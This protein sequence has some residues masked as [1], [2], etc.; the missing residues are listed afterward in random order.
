MK[1][2]GKLIRLKGSPH[3]FLVRGAY[4]SRIANPTVYHA[5]EATLAEIHNVNKGEFDKYKTARD[6]ILK[7]IDVPSVVVPR[8]K[9][10]SIRTEL[11]K[12]IEARDKEIA[13]L[14]KKLTD[15]RTELNK[16]I[17]AR[18]KEIAELIEGKKDA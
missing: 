8:E 12:V 9:S 15:L 17:E 5:M 11:N 1:I 13:E 16:V 3:V 10:K 4:K 18:D 14:K 2:E 7:D 6:F